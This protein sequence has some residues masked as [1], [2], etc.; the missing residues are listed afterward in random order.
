MIIKMII[1][2]FTIDLAM[3][4]KYIYCVEKLIISLKQI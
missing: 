1:D 3:I 2:T 4:K